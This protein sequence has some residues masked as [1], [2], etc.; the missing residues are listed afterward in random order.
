MLDI[1]SFFGKFKLVLSSGLAEREFVAR[2]ISEKIGV[3]IKPEEVSIKNNEAVVNVSPMAKSR[4]FI[5]KQAILMELQE[6]L[7]KKIV[8]IR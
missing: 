6:K 2:K 4:I 1:N 3:V 5:H 7:G 8:N